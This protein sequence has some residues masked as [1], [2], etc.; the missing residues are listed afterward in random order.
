MYQLLAGEPPYNGP[1]LVNLF[2]A[3]RNQAVPRLDEKRPELP[4][5]VCAVVTRLL[6][7][8]PRD[9]YQTGAEL[10]H[11]LLRIYDRLRQADAN[12]SRRESRDSLRSLR[13]F[14]NFSDEDIN[15]IL[16]SSQLQS[17]AAGAEIVREGDI[18]AAFYL[19]ARGSAEVRKGKLVLDT[20]TRGDCFGEIAFLTAARRTA[21]V[22]ATAPVLALRVSATL[23]DRLTTDCQLRFYKTFTNTLIYR[24]TLTSAK[25]QAAKAP[26]D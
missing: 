17:F 13:F 19:I 12:V 23:M 10:S 7:K 11:E 22:A 24:L 1:D 25:L 18:D 21:T 14:D 2:A 3:I 6:Q 26:H 8:D 15:E 4:R 20:L 16:G 5:E 9:R